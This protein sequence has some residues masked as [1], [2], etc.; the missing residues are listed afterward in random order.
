[1]FTCEMQTL[2]QEFETCDCP[3]DELSRVIQAE[4]GF[5]PKI[6]NEMCPRGQKLNVSIHVDQCIMIFLVFL[7]F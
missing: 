1:M 4:N 6:V 3:D 5:F 2:S 7:L